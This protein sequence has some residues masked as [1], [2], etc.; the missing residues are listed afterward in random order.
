MGRKL[1]SILALVIVLG[2]IYWQQSSILH[3]EVPK[4]AGTWKALDTSRELERPEQPEAPEEPE[5]PEQPEVPEEPEPPEETIECFHVSIPQEDGENGYYI[6]KPEVE[7]THVS[8]AGVT[9]YQFADSEG[10]MMEGEL[11]QK[12]DVARIAGEQ[13]KEG[14]NR[15]SIWMED[16]EGKQVEEYRLDKDFLIDTQAPAIWLGAP[17]GFEAWYQETASIT[18]TGEDGELGSQI[19]EVVC[20]S[21]NSLIGKSKELP[22]TFQVA[23]ASAKGNSIKITVTARDRAGNTASRSC[24]L[25]IDRQPPKARIEGIEDYMITSKPVEIGRA[26]V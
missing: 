17:R 16:G 24:G 10:Q 13:F 9:K 11:A 5:I 20:A 21:G 12:D 22:A 6:S 25:Y 4:E 1:K 8:G 2:M 15:L 3:A 18:V 26:H 23:Y 14:I 7:I 19:E